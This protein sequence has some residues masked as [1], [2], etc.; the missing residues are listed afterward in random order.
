MEPG[1][2]KDD[3]LVSAGHNME[4]NL[5]SDISNDG[6]QSG[7]MSD[8]TKS[9]GGL[10]HVMDQ[11]WFGQFLEWEAV[12]VCELPVKAVNGS[13]RVNEGVGFDVFEHVHRDN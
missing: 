10:V 8:S 9:V 11:G 6:K 7:D 1:H 13:P 12:F 3:V 5:M 2:S 4:A